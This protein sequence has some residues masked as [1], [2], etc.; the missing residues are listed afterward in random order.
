MSHE[1]DAVPGFTELDERNILS[2]VSTAIGGISLWIRHDPTIASRITNIGDGYMSDLI[3]CDSIVP[4][5]RKSFW[6]SPL[7]LLKLLRKSRNQI[8]M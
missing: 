8:S 7:S 5:Y 6:G 4:L 1:Y 3:V 2:K